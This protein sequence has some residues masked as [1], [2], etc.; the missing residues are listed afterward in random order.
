MIMFIRVNFNVFWSAK[1]YIY[2]CTCTTENIRIQYKHIFLERRKI[3][4]APFHKKVLQT[5]FNVWSKDMSLLLIMT[6]ATQCIN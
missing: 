5:I 4:I 2:I 6:R 1:V 3:L